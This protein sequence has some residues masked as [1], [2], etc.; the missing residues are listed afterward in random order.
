MKLLLTIHEHANYT[1]RKL[2]HN[3]NTQRPTNIALKTEEKNMQI[4]GLFPYNVVLGAFYN[5]LEAK[6]LE[7]MTAK[8]DSINTYKTSQQFENKE[9]NFE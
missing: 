4:R 6:R 1:L 3:T 8:W 9:T 5:L 7:F 2:Q